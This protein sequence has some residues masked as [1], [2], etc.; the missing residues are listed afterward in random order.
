MTDSLTTNQCAAHGCQNKRGEGAFIGDFCAPCDS[1]L[2]YGV[3]EFGTSFIFQQQREIERLRG[4]IAAAHSHQ[5][6]AC[7]HAYTPVG[8]EDCP[9]CGCDGTGNADETNEDRT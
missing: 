9:K 8:N 5:C 3:A 6:V 4:I 1:A 2:R 7:G